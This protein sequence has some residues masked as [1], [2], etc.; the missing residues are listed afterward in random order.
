[1][2]VYV[3][4]LMSHGWR[5][6]GKPT[7]NAHLFADSVEELHAFAEALGLRRRWFQYKPGK[8]PHYDVTPGFYW[9]AI[10]RGAVHLER[11]EAVAK[12]REIKARDAERLDGLARRFADLR[13]AFAG[14]GELDTPD[15]PRMS[16]TATS[17]PLSS[18]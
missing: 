16:T 1:M 13:A 12:M 7:D 9:Q 17:H 2:A 5:L 8:L 15:F 3:D 18:S 14:G 6:R 11:A 10:R 4:S